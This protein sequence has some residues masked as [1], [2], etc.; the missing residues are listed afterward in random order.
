[1]ANSVHYPPIALENG[2]QGKVFVSFVVD[3]NGSISNVKIT[4]GVDPSLDKEAIRVVKSMPKWI[5]GK[6]NGQAVR[7][8]F[9]VP[10]NFVLQ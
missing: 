5:P 3:T 8:S 1:L 2:V 7:V 4:R 6:Q 9:T 10:I